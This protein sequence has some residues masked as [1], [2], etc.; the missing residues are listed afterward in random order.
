[1]Q[2]ITKKKK[3]TS[4]CK[5]KMYHDDIITVVTRVFAIVFLLFS[6]FITIYHLCRIYDETYQEN[7]GNRQRQKSLKIH[8]NLPTITTTADTNKSNSGIF[9]FTSFFHFGDVL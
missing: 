1:M 6:I 2:K 8:S 4:D 9:D 7:H 5:A 3:L